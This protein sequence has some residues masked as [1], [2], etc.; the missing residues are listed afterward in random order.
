MIPI[1][2]PGVV[3]VEESGISAHD[4]GGEENAQTKKIMMDDDN[5][6]ATSELGRRSNLFC[7]HSSSLHSRCIVFLVPCTP[8]FLGSFWV[9]TETLGLSSTFSRPRDSDFL[10]TVSSTF[11]LLRVPRCFY[12][13]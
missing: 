1:F 5:L 3:S 4:A 12:I 6:M 9:L 10:R 2:V 11:V 13:A 8:V 7:P